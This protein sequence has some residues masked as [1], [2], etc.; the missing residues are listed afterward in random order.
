MRQAKAKA[1]AAG[2]FVR[3]RLANHAFFDVV[4]LPTAQD[5]PL[6]KPD[7]TTD[8]AYNSLSTSQCPSHLS[9]ENSGRGSGLTSLAHWALA[10]PVVTPIGPYFS[11]PS[12]LTY[13][14]TLLMTGMAFI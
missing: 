2:A 14:L 6:P 9:P 10:S 3:S 13:S 1:T 7:K 4:W 11:P 5:K 12:P 8:N